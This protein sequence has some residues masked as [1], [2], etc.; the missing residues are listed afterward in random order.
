MKNNS[1]ELFESASIPK[2]F[3]KLTIPTVLSKLVMVLYNLV[4]TWFISAT[5]DTALVAAVSL[6]L[7]VLSTLSA[8]GDVWGVGGSALMSRLFG[9]GKQEKAKQVSA[10][11]FYGGLACGVIA[12]AVMFL[13]QEPLLNILGVDPTTYTYAV[14]YYR[15]MALGG[16]AVILCCVTMHMLRTEGLATESMLGSIVGTVVHIVLVPLLIFRMDMGIAGAAWA[17]VWGYAA[18]L[19]ANLWY[20]LRRCRLSTL[21]PRA[22]QVRWETLSPVM[23]IG[24][25]AALTTFMQSVALTLTNRYLLIY[26]TEQVA[27]YGIAMKLVM[28]A[29]MFQVGFS[30]GA[31]PLIGYNYAKTDRTRFKAILKFNYS[32]MTV[33]SLICA[34]LIGAFAPQLMGFFMDDAAIVAAGTDLVRY[35]AAGLVFAGIVLVSTTVFRSAGKP[36]ESLL[37]SISR[38][39]VVYAVV[40]VAANALAGYQG[41]LAAQPVADVVSAIAAAFIL[42]PLLKS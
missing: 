25:P 9:E 39:G 41:I 13:W 26:G 36:V 10:L 24:I 16:P 28:M 18:N 31:Q 20:M 11:C 21:S 6:C 35:Q 32:F 3:L 14:E 29:M 7:P 27:A 38:Q 8:I 37:L 40:L 42:R 2:A 23:S 19:A 4:D 12:V 5:N 30:F 1:Q 33:V 22:V 17:T 34:V 15:I